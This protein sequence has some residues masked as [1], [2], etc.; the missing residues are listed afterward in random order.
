MTS[1]PYPYEL[2]VKQRPYVQIQLRDAALFIPRTRELGMEA[3][4]NCNTSSKQQHCPAYNTLK[5]HH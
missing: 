3:N 1:N 5:H 4:S 2:D